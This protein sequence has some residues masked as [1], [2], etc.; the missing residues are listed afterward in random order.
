M[1]Y[2][3]KKKDLAGN[4]GQSPS[5]G[6]VS[7]LFVHKQNI[8]KITTTTTTTFCVSSRPRNSQKTSRAFPSVPVRA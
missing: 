6:Q 3:K 5:C 4:V 7:L 2:N 8:K 1:K